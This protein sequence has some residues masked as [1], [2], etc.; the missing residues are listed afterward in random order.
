MDEILHPFETMGSHC[1][2]VF[3]GESFIP[4]FLRWCRI[5]SIHSMVTILSLAGAISVGRLESVGKSPKLY[6]VDNWRANRAMHTNANNG[7]LNQILHG[8][9]GSN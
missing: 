8:K 9:T 1:S 4:G 7:L 2:L 3:T 6:I 5:S